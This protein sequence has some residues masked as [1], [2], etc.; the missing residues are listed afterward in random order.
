[1]AKKYKNKYKGNANNTQNKNSDVTHYEVNNSHDESISEETLYDVLTFAQQ[2]YGGQLTNNIMSPELTN[3]R[4]KDST[5]NPLAG[6][7]KDIEKALL[8][9]K[10]SEKQLVG[11]SEFF[12]L[13]S[14]IYKRT[15]MYLAN[16]LSFSI[17]D[18][19]CTNAE[20]KDYTSA[21]YKKDYAEVCNFLDK[22]KIKEEFPK[23]MR[24][25]LR[26]DA[27]F[28][29]LRD[30][31]DKYT[32]Q[33][34]PNDYCILTGRFSYGWLFDYNMYWFTQ[35]GVNI[36]MYPSV[37]KEMYHGIFS[38]ENSK[39]DSA[40]KLNM[41]D[42]TYVYWAQTSPKDGFWAWK[43]TPETATRIPYLTPLFQDV[44]YQPMV[45][46]LQMNK[47]VIDATKIMVGLIPLLNDAKAGNVKDMIA[48][49]SETAGKFLSLLKRGISDTIK[50]GAVPFSDVKVIDFEDSKRNMLEDYTKVT[51][52]QTGVNSKL[53]FP[54]DKQNSLETQMSADIDVM[55][56]AYMYE[57]FE[58]FL[59]YQINQRTSKFKFDINL[60]GTNFSSDKKERRDEA[61]YWADKG[62]VLPNRIAYAL[63]IPPHHLY[64]GL[65]EA[66]AKGFSDLMIPLLNI[67]TTP[68]GEAAGKDEKKDGVKTTTKQ[69]TKKTTTESTKGRPKKELGDLSD[70]G[71][72]TRGDAENLGKV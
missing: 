63:D 58:N 26:K 6:T 40:A 33:E 66:N 17:K 5:L 14:M 43:L 4:L 11:F 44:A 55:T 70:S 8:N 61:G 71:L 15:L 68:G 50:T 18:I 20:S 52:S 45:R 42:G 64:K 27:F 23:V 56:V 39:Y 24:Q 37:F 9:P 69:T 46:Q 53:V 62:V 54:I 32:L 60:A 59:N 65:E 3:S 25:M 57:F 2:L 34:L 49:S 10:D 38:G 48:I 12:E 22:F 28:S 21:E 19:V 16:V 72:Q 1:M 30:D 13:T 51:A 36:D 35:P 31:G 47:Y 29:I 41:R 67:F 7:Q